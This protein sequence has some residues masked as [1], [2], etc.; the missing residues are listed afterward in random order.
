MAVDLTALKEEVLSQLAQEDF[1]IFYADSGS[2][3]LNVI[4]WDIKRHPHFAEF[5]RTAEKCGSKLVMFYERRFS[6]VSIDEILERLENS[7]LS[8][9][10]RRSYESRLKELQKFEGFTCELEISF[11]HGHHIY[12]YQARTDWFEEFEDIFADVAVGDSD[13]YDDEDEEDGPISGYFSRN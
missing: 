13:L 1:A 10:E 9:E 2:E 3:G 5:L 12:V 11:E 7:E 4:H 8:R 6:Q